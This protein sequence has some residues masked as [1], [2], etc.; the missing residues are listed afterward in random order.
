[1]K[2]LFAC[3][4]MLL[5]SVAAHAQGGSAFPSR[6]VKI[7]LGFAAG[8]GTDLL[9]RHYARRLGEKLGQPFVVENRPGKGGA[10]AVY[11]TVHSPADG[12]TL[13]LGTTGIAVDAALGESS[14]D[15]Q[16]DLVPVSL[17]AYAP[18]VLVVPAKSSIRSV[19][20]VIRQAKQ[21]HMTFGSAGVTSSM[22]MSG[23][24]FKQMAGIE[25]TH[26]PYRGAAPAEQ[27]LLG[28]EIDVMFDNLAG[29][30]TFIAAG[31][32]RA[33]A[34]SSRV[35]SPELPD[36]PTIAESGLPGF[37]TTGSFFLM[38][39]AKTPADVV[40]RLEAV[41]DEISSE[42]ATQAYIKKMHMVPLRGGGKAVSNLL[43]SD[44]AKWKKVVTAKGFVID[45]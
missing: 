24:L 14:Y 7:N 22:H 34:I 30:A 6:P 27:A 13:V 43:Q 17:L 8:G 20:D 25:M 12:Y 16:R 23:E 21:T 41:V 26:V 10:I 36:V 39:P 28:G 9:A 19:A 3:I 2:R 15:W 1:M 35:R 18:N 29:A 11:T 45:K 44:Y 31:K 37:E 32:F 40:K 42:E 4:L 38:A 33:I 5:V